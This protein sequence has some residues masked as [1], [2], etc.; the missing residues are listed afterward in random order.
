M[1]HAAHVVKPFG[2]VFAVF[3]G[4]AAAVA[5]AADS[6]A[7]EDSNTESWAMETIVVTAE[8]GG[9]YEPVVQTATRT[10]TPV[11]K[12]PQSIQSLNRNLIEDQDLQ[13]LTTALLNVSGVMPTTPMQTVLQAT[14]LR[15]FGV[16]YYFDGLPTYQ[17]PPGIADPGTLINVERIEVA[18]GPTSTLYGGGAGAPLSG[19]VN[20]VSRDPVQELG[21]SFSLRTG[22][23]DT[24]GGA[25]DIN[26]PLGEQVA[27]RLSAMAEQSDSHIDV[28]DSERYAVFPSLSW[29]IT[30]HTRLL[31][32]GRFNH[33]EQQEYAGLPVELIKPEHLISRDVYAGANDSPRTEIENTQ[34][35]AFLTHA[36]SDRLEM[37]IAIGLYE[38]EFE[39]W[40]SFP[41][42]QI[43][44][45]LYNFGTGFLP[46]DT[47][48]RFA[49]ASVTA[50]LGEGLVR[51][52]LLAGVDWDDTDYFGAL[53]FNPFWSL[54][55]Y[56]AADPTASFGAVPP[57]FFD[58]N[59]DLS[60]TAV[61][62]QDQISIGERLDLTLGLR[63]TSLDIQ[64]VV[65]G[66]ET[67]DT[68]DRITPRVGAT[69]EVVDGLSVFAGY[70]EGFQ[71]VVAGGFLGIVPKPESSKSYEAGFKFAAPITGLTGTVAVYELTRRNV[72]TPDPVIPFTFVQTG[73]QRARGVEADLIYE[74]SPA[75]S[76]LFS[77]AYT[78][79]EVTKDNNLPKGDRLRA[80][81][82]HSGRLAVRYRFAGTSLD[83]LEIGAGLTAV[84]KR[85]LTLPNTTAIGGFTVMDAQVAYHIGA[86]T[87]TLSLQNLLDK[88]GF[89]P[90]QYL[91]GA[92]VVPT[93]P[94]SA[95]LTIQA[96][97]W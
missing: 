42:G 19:I 14:L 67:D 97:T 73:E 94:R 2:L 54:L 32:R 53:Y 38:G 43:A 58:Q 21:G 7:A 93:Q 71:G 9:L 11:E 24:V 22:S 16:S 84:S 89:E 28:I 4:S 13:N 46:S 37:N 79:A 70:S 65:S 3:L 62:V 96:G 17:L 36:F 30:D 88:G 55:D 34:V 63:W 48:K 49:T 41:F 47:D 85:E 31:L 61:F 64:S 27:I 91:G 92:F 60:S 68:D 81:P 59:D 18:K 50:R 39:E 78:D 33:L 82:E 26:V 10:D 5:T 40:A 29:D 12:I 35:G 76:L 1:K 51:H 80:V 74:P 44:G 72:A 56:S 23:F 45:T 95:F 66:L 8:R 77:Y 83:G 6:T 87:L 57:L 69:F 20:L 52:Q 75:L 25:A 15:G 90:Y 86:A